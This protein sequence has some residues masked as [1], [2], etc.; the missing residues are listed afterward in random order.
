MPIYIFVQC[1]TPASLIVFFL[2]TVLHPDLHHVSTVCSSV[3]L[4]HSKQL[5]FYTYSAGKVGNYFLWLPS[6]HSNPS[7]SPSLSLSHGRYGGD[8]HRFWKE[9]SL[10]IHAMEKALYAI[11][12][13]SS[14][15]KLQPAPSLNTFN[16]QPPP[17]K[18]L[19]GENED[20]SVL[21]VA[22]VKVSV[23]QVRRHSLD[24]GNE[25]HGDGILRRKKLIFESKITVAA[26]GK[27][28]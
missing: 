2:P 22:C 28:K 8:R 26:V 16:T 24:S 25:A 21:K 13:N 5:I 27:A 17:S 12:L 23:C 18:C 6:F 11:W 4:D 10:P 20:R 15:A 1:R 19:V 14:G 7:S 3:H 9:G